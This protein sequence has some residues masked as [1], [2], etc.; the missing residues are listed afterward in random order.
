MARNLQTVVVY[1]YKARWHAPEYLPR[2]GTWEAIGQLD[3]C[4]PIG[5]SARQVPAAEVDDDGFL[6]FGV[7]P[8]DL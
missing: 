6:P 4:I 8:E 5:T 2:W 7:N 3:G 1:R